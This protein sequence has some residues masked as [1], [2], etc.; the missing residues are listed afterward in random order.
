M[1]EAFSWPEGSLSLSTGVPFA[2]S[3][4]I[5][6]CEN[7]NLTEKWGWNN[8]P[9]ASG[10]YSD[11]LTGQRADVTF[12]AVFTFDKTALRM[13]QAATAVHMKLNHNTIN[14][15]AGVYL[16]SGRIDSLTLQ[17][18]AAGVYHYTMQAHFNVWTAYP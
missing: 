2:T 1:P 14:G 4:L 10:N 5:A 13:A 3:A 18:Q 12:G 16:Y 8:I 9:A 17:G 6:Y 15:S 11:T 7:T